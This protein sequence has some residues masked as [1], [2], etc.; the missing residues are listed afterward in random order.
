MRPL[1][2]LAATLLISGC[3]LV[4]AKGTPRQMQEAKAVH[5][6]VSSI[7]PYGQ[8]VAAADAVYRPRLYGLNPYFG[9]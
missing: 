9:R 6:F 7:G 1:I 4:G 5:A 8:R 2:V 3:S